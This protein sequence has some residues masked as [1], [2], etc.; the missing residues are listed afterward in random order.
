MEFTR[1]R[2]FMAGMLLILLGIQFRM[3]HSFV[4]NEPATRTLI[5]LSKNA[6][7]AA[8]TPS[9]FNQFFMQV[10]PSPRKQVVPP[11]WLGLAMVAVGVVISL[12][13]L[14]MPRTG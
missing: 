5:K 11:R 7:V 14:A 8:S 9:T 10:T 12:H 2:Y 1:N 6:P 3:V 4:L 13:A